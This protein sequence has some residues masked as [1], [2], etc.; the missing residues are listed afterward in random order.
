MANGTTPTDWGIATT[1]GF[2]DGTIVSNSGTIGGWTIGTYTL[3][4]GTLGSNNSMC[5][6]TFDLTNAE[7]VS[8]GGS[9][10]A[11]TTWR[12]GAGSKFGVT[13]DGDC[14]CSNI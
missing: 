9:S 1:N 3:T 12:I 7:A 2:F 4:N 13:K 5:L 11:L 14:Y 10:S 6:R 8:I